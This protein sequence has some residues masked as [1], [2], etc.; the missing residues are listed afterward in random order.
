MKAYQVDDKY[1]ENSELVYADN[2][3]K[4]KANAWKSDNLCDVDFIDL[5]ARRAKYADD[6]EH[7][8]EVERICFLCANGWW[9]EFDDERWDEEN[10]KELFNQLSKE[11]QENVSVALNKLGIEVKGR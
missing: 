1:G 9:Y 3:N 11:G 2:A 4:A 7:L 8:K 5:R 6:T 10:W